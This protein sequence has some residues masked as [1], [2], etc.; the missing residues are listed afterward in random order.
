MTPVRR[1]IRPGCTWAI[2]LLL[3]TDGLP[4]YVPGGDIQALLEAREPARETC[5]QFVEA[6][7]RAGGTDNIPVIVARL[8][9]PSQGTVA[10]EEAAVTTGLS[11][12]TSLPAEPACP[13]VIAAWTQG[14]AGGEAHSAPRPRAAATVQ[15]QEGNPE[16]CGPR[17]G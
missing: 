14:N 17:W 15:R 4:K 8:R 7:N 13:A 1:S 10:A 16:S 6:A 3:C 9:H 2:P 12:A 5:R 11:A